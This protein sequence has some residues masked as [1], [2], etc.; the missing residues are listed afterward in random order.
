M[1]AHVLDTIDPAALGAQLMEARKAR[2]LTQQ[3]VADALNVARTTIVAMEKGDRRPRA[4]EL[5]QLAALYG[6]TVGDLVRATADPPRESF[7]VQFRAARTRSDAER[8]EKREADIREFE[9]LCRDYA[10]LERITNSPSLVV[11]PMSMT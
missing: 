9:A 7:V 5:V 11:I 4:S 10:E 8:D 3:A 2:G 1:P 6:R